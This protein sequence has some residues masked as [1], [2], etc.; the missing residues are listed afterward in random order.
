MKRRTY[1]APNL[2]G[3]WL[4]LIRMV[5][6]G[7]RLPFK[8]AALRRPSGR[9]FFRGQSLP[10]QIRAEKF[11]GQSLPIEFGDSGSLAGRKIGCVAAPPIRSRNI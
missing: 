8:L 9:E 5:I 4:P 6:G 1:S 3:S 11:E 10:L 7:Q 2:R